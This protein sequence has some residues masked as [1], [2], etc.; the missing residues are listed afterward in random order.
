MNNELVQVCV[1][2][3]C[4]DRAARTQDISTEL[5]LRRSTDKLNEAILKKSDVISM[6]YNAKSKSLEANPYFI[7]LNW[8]STARMMWGL[9]VRKS[10]RLNAEAFNY[11]KYRQF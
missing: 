11:E 6:Y 10:N 3:L 7:T 9:I 1:S 2:F 5:A 8:Q 4:G